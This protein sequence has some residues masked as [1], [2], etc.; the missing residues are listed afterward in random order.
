MIWSFY[1]VLLIIIQRP[2]LLCMISTFW[3]SPLCVCL[4]FLHLLLKVWKLAHQVF[5]FIYFWFISGATHLKRLNSARCISPLKNKISFLVI[6]RQWI[7]LSRESTVKAVFG[8]HKDGITFWKNVNKPHHTIHSNTNYTRKDPLSP[9]PSLVGG[10]EAL[11]GSGVVPLVLASCAQ[12][13]SVHTGRGI[14]EFVWLGQQPGTR[15]IL[16]NVEHCVNT[17]PRGFD[18]ILDKKRLQHL[19]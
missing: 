16:Y 4:H 17:E 10:N 8:F 15:L 1:L 6:T 18:M 2:A 9:T 12:R 5:F 7:S 14:P 19:K 3:L 11:S 13:P